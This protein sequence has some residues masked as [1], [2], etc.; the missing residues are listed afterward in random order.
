M[1][2]GKLCTKCKVNEQHR[3]HGGLC[4]KCRYE[5]RATSL[6]CEKCKGPKTIR[7]AYC[8]RCCNERRKNAKKCLGCGSVERV[9][10]GTCYS[11]SKKY[12]LAR[13]DREIGTQCNCGRGLKGRNFKCSYCNKEDRQKRKNIFVECQECGCKKSANTIRRCKRCV[14]PKRELRLVKVLAKKYGCDPSIIA[15]MKQQSACEICNRQG[16]KPFID[17]CHQTGKVRGVLCRWCNSGIGFFSDNTELLRKAIDY[18]ESP[19]IPIEITQSA[20]C[21]CGQSRRGDSLTCQKCKNRYRKGKCS[22]CD[23]D[24]EKTGACRDCKQT[25]EIAKRLNISFGLAKRCRMVSAC[26]ACNAKL[27]DGANIDHCHATGIMRGVLC[28]NCNI[29]L[30]M[31]KDNVVTAKNAIKYIEHHKARL[32][33]GP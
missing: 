5:Q 15:R 30:G 21:A 2:A 24:S 14:R 22:M 9:C 13:I 20:T 3:S 1:R 11:C 7:G 27:D 29:G 8:N 12:R 33:H 4:S 26:E 10:H 28:N 19:R 23:N 18:I 16:I 25:R 6:V 31:L 32:L 17:H